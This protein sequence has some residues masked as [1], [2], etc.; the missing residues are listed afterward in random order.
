MQERAR[1]LYNFCKL[2]RGK[3]AQNL[4]DSLFNF[5]PNR[6]CLQV[7]ILICFVWFF[8]ILHFNFFFN[9]FNF[10]NFSVGRNI[11]HRV[12]IGRSVHFWTKIQCPRVILFKKNVYEYYWFFSSYF[13]C[14][15]TIVCLQQNFRVVI[16]IV[17]EAQNLFFSF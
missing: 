12:W 5:L 6:K 9:S 14:E 4:S 11:E 15:L 13:Q 8:W 3:S 2:Q 17:C 10:F 16:I 7:I 1:I